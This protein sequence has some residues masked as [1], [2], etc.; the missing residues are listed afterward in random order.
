MP[1]NHQRVVVERGARSGFPI[2]VAVHSTALGQAVGGCRL[3]VYSDWRD[4][5]DDALRLS[6]AMTSKTALAGLPNGGGKTVVALPRARPVDR[7]A[8]LH[9]VA[10]V[11]E[12][13]GGIYATGPDVGTGPG[14]MVTIGERT[15]HVLC[16]DGDSS[17]GTAA[18]VLAALRAVAAD[19]FGSPDPAGRSFA[20]LGVGRVGTHVVRLLSAAGA[21]V[22]CS[23]VDASRRTVA[24]SLGATWTDPRSC[25]T[26]EV[27]VLV[28]AAL[29]GVLTPA[30][31]PALRC[32]AV[33]GPANNQLDEPATADLL[34][35][36]GILWAPDVVVS[37]GGIIHALATGLH[38]EEPSRVAARIAAVGETLAGI[39]EAAR[40]TSST[41]AAAASRLADWL[42][43]SP[44]GAVPA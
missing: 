1:L 24:E 22:L 34:H 40:E 44:T 13:L 16:R 42:I 27:D 9:D 2:I 15:N 35:A 17:P 7:R 36:R 33:A 20:V 8:V 39:L 5:F 11:I 14:D 4:G 3:A 10:D 19:R 26:A 28:P 25:L 32:A 37:A 41:P 12:G 21:R 18:G 6:A 29:G 30:T 23:D 38:R 43:G 31:V